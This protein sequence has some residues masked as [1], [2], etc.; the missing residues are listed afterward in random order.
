M[1][2]RFI[3]AAILGITLSCLPG[4]TQAQAPDEEK[5]SLTSEIFN[6]IDQE[7]IKRLAIVPKIISRDSAGENPA[8]VGELGPLADRLATQLR[9]E[10]RKVNDEGNFKITIVPDGVVKA[11]LKGAKAGDLYDESVQSK[12]RKQADAVILLFTNADAKESTS[13]KDLEIKTEMLDIRV[14]DQTSEV[15]NRPDTVQL[16]LSDAA[17]AGQ[18]FIVRMVNDSKIQPVN[19][20]PMDGIPEEAAFGVGEDW[21]RIQYAQLEPN[22]QHPLQDSSNPFAFQVVVNGEPREIWF[23]PKE[24]NKAYVALNLDEEFSVRLHNHSNMP[25][26]Q[27]LIIDGQNSISQKP[28]VSQEE[29]HPIKTDYSRHWYIKPAE[30]YVSIDGYLR[31]WAGKAGANNSKSNRFK[32]TISTEAEAVKA[33][34]EDKLGLFTVIVYALRNQGYAEYTQPVPEKIL[35]A[36]KGGESFKLGIGAGAQEDKV[37]DGKV[38]ER[39]VMLTAMTVYYVTPKQLDDLKSGAGQSGG[40]T[41][42]GT[43]TDKPGPA[44]V[45]PAKTQTGTTPGKPIVPG[46]KTKTVGE[47]TPF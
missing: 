30:T 22:E 17:Y 37:I 32:V 39:G 38:G 9:D 14:A 2:R 12:L 33:G 29:N 28:D 8:F 25:V 34:I 13:F 20:K 41:A 31:Q 24:D 47:E 45:E 44:K 4:G 15:V 35:V 26:L 16:T 3:A 43:Q 1:V 40:N 11:A 21:E 6:K 18:S 36:S 19:F 46:L 27:S 42:G 5:I 10:I 7:K 23:N